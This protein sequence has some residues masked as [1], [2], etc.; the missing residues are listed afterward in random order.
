MNRHYI[1]DY[2]RSALINFSGLIGVENLDTNEIKN[3]CIEQLLSDADADKYK[4]IDGVL[5]EA[6]P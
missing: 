2:S 3:I 4:S 6:A 5:Y 1:N